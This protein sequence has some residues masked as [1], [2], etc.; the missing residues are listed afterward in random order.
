MGILLFLVVIISG[1]GDDELDLDVD[2][3][4]DVNCWDI[5]TETTAEGDFQVGQILSIFGIGKAPLIV[6]LATD[7]SLLGLLGWM[8]NVVLFSVT[9]IYPSGFLAGVVLAL[10]LLTS[11][12]GGGLMAQPIGKIFASFWEDTRSDYPKNTGQADGLIGCHGTV[13]SLTIPMENQG[14]IGQVD[15][16]DSACN[17][18]R[19]S[20]TLPTWAKVVPSHGTQVLV[21]D[22]QPHSYLV[23]AKDSSDEQDWLVILQKSS[24][25]VTGNG[26]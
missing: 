3:D 26:E 2:L 19:I 17:L 10:S 16:V 24:N 9:G 4:A 22:R 6:L 14:Q 13:S 20:A 21:I 12:L 23:I 18:V 1:E 11:L 15:I 8:F 7:F 5:H 25:R